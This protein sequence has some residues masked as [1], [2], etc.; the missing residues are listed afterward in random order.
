MQPAL[1][2]RFIFQERTESFLCGRFYVE[3]TDPQL[4]DLLETVNRSPLTG[5]FREKISGD[6]PASGEIFPSAV[7]PVIAPDRKGEKKAFPMRWG[8]SL[9][10]S[11]S[12]APRLMIN[13]RSETAAEKPL[14]RDA[15]ARHRCAVPA[16]W[17]FEWEHLPLP[18]GRQKV[19]RKFAIRPREKGLVWLAGLYRLEEG[20][21]V[22]TVLTRT[23][24]AD[25]SRIH[26]RM[27][28]M[29]PEAVV[30]AWISPDSDPASLRS[31]ALTELELTGE[32]GFS[33]PSHE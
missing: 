25:V 5:L 8:F 32:D 23:P 14:F 19:G 1:F 28:L 18:D 24:S 33:H 30:P 27:P 26:N 9:P 6:I 15:W 2:R 21:P 22:F 16:S 11:A 20:L 13:A 17:Y 29:L 12:S 10:R 3:Y 4:R 7:V 31:S